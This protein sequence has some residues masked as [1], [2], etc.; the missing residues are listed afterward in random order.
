MKKEVDFS[1]L[2]ALPGHVAIIMDGNGRWAKKRLQP[3]SFGHR[4]GMENVKRI[5]RTASDV[6]IRALTLYAFS[7][8]NWKRP[9]DE[10]GVLM[11][12][13]IE[14]LRREMDELCEKRIVF[15]TIGDMSRL[16]QPVQD[17]LREAAERMQDN[18]GMHLTV[19][20]NYGSRAEI[21]AAAAAVAEAYKRGEVEAVTQDAFEA[22]L[23][24]DGLPEIDLVIRTSG[25]ERISNFLLY[26]IAYAELYFTDILWP[27]FDEA[28]LY[29]AL[30]VYEGRKRRFGGI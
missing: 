19:A 10:V 23:M 21:A 18:D 9:S 14:Y 28:A 4:A 3:R 29:E 20:V 17:I 8:E 1:K 12:L 24:T 7:T 22:H 13:L 26:Q 11:K 27:D 15:R 6:G 25:E 30:R 5:V 2:S 16:P